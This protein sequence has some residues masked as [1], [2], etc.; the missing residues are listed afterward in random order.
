MES[1][2]FS[3]NEE[4]NFNFNKSCILKDVNIVPKI[5]R[6]TPIA[7]SPVN[8]SFKKIKLKITVTTAAE[9]DIGLITD[10]YPAC[11]PL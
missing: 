1:W 10:T 11:N 7:C 8:V 4:V 3:P 6:I 9:E 2:D 5:A